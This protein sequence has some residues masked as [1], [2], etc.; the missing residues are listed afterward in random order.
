MAI[1]RDE[2]N[3]KLY[4]GYRKPVDGFAVP[5]TPGWEDGAC[6]DFCKYNPDKAKE[7]LTKSGYTGK[8]EI[9]SNADG[10]HKEWIE[11]ACGS[12]KNTIGLDCQFVPVQTFGEVRKKI[13]A[14]T[15]TQMYRGGW[16]A[17]YP[18]IENFLNPLYRTGGSSNDGLYSNPAVDS[19]LAEADKATTIDDANKLYREAEKMIAQ[20]MPSIPLWATP[21]LYVYSNKIKNV[22]MTPRGQ[23]DLG[24]VDM[25]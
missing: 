21:R 4:E 19:K 17:D 9:T 2:I 8:I 12:I 25:I 24:F 6:G 1:N 7:A 13:T 18:S 16:I 23:I 3:K 11:A 10:G 20:D 5:K 22:R 15:M 14:H